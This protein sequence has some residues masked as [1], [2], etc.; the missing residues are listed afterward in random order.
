MDIAIFHTRQMPCI[1]LFDI[2]QVRI[3]SA[4]LG[5]VV[6]SFENGSAAG[7]GRN[8]VFVVGCLDLFV[9]FMQVRQQKTKARG[10]AACRARRSASKAIVHDASV[11]KWIG[12]NSKCF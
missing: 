1:T 3:A 11:G 10:R 8:P 4:L 5:C 9:V 12:R 6:T 2:M 7:S